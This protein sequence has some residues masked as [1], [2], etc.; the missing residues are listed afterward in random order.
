MNSMGVVGV[1][2]R[3]IE[4]VFPDVEHLR[5]LLQLLQLLDDL[6]PHLLRHCGLDRVADRG[7]LDLHQQQIVAVPGVDQRLQP[8]RRDDAGV[9]DWSSWWMAGGCT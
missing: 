9:H 3:V 4:G 7:E 5:V 2:V 8:P 1:V 6:A